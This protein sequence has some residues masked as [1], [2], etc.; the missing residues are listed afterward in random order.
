[1][2]TLLAVALAAALAAACAP[3]PVSRRSSYHPSDA[4][5]TVTRIV[6]ASVILELG[7]TRLLVDPWFHSGFLVRQREPLG[8]TPE[9]LPSLAAVLITHPHADRFDPRAL[10]TL[11]AT[12]PKAIAR[13]ELHARLVELGFARVTDLGWWDTASVGGVQ[14]TA[15]PARHGVPEN[16]YVLEGGGVRVYVAGDT[17]DFPELVDVRTRFPDLDAALLTV[18]GMRLFGFRRE[19]GP[20]EA[21]RIGARV[22]ARRLIPVAYGESGGFPV[23][24]FARRPVDRFIEACA[25]NGIERSRVVV[26]QPG[27]SWHYYK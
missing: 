19:T 12:V 17:R 1:M 11:A 22:D 9:G 8:M 16:G 10:R 24:W 25:E 5:L 23:R 14:V 3:L 20:E 15:V 18:G 6:H 21:A 7:R 13:P 4:D 27:E 26:L 2:R